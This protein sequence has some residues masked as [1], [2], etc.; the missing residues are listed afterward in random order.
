MCEEPQENRYLQFA[1]SCSSLKD[2]IIILFFRAISGIWY[3]A[4]EHDIYQDC[5]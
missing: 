4:K 5:D 1:A 2:L 3:V